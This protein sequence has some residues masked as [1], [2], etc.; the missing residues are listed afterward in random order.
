MS[1]GEAAFLRAVF[2]RRRTTPS[3]WV[4]ITRDAGLCQDED[5]LKSNCNAK[6]FML[7]RQARQS[8]LEICPA[9]VY[10]GLPTRSRNGPHRPDRRLAG[11]PCA[12]TFRLRIACDR[13]LWPPAG[14]ISRTD[15]RSH[16]RDR[17]FPDRRCLRRHGA[18]NAFRSLG[19]FRGPG[20]LRT[21]HHGNGRDGKPYHALSTSHSRLLGRERGNAG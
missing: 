17:R 1:A 5:G 6:N 21:F 8:G 14:R 3:I 4:P 19:A 12:D 18:R 13:G 16:H 2:K 9:S 15:E 10:M 7:F 20:H 11:P